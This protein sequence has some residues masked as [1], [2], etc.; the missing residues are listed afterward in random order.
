[1]AGKGANHF[2]GSSRQVINGMRRRL[3]CPGRDN[4]TYSATPTS[5]TVGRPSRPRET[6]LPWIAADLPTATH[7][8]SKS[9]LSLPEP[10]MEPGPRAC[11]LP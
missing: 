2:G 11:T 3:I 8:A 10:S 5:A 6:A 4:Q 7:S 9:S 1:M